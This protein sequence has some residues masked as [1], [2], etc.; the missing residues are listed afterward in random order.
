MS[1]LQAQLAAL[2]EGNKNPGLVH[3]VSKRHEEALG[4]GVHYSVQQGHAVRR[5][6]FAASYLYPSAKEA[7]KVSLSVVEEKAKQAFGKLAEVEP[8]LMDC[9]GIFHQEAA[10]DA[11]VRKVLLCLTSLL[12]ETSDLE[13]PC[14]AMLEY[15]VRRYDVHLRFMEELV[16]TVVSHTKLLGRTLQLVDLGSVASYNWLR[17]YA[18]RP[19]EPI[20]RSQLAQ[21]VIHHVDWMRRLCS[22]SVALVELVDEESSETRRGIAQMLSFT[23]TLVVEG[24]LQTNH[25]SEEMLR[26]LLPTLLQACSHPTCADWRGWGSVVA[27]VVAEKMDLAPKTV[28][29]ITCALL[30][31][32]P[33]PVALTAALAVLLPPQPMPIQDVDQYLKV[34]KGQLLGCNLPKE[35]FQKLLEWADELP[36]LLGELNEQLV[37]APFVATLI[38]EALKAKR[39]GLVACLL[40]EPGLA[41]LWN[42]DRIA[43]ISSLASYCWNNQIHE[44]SLWQRLHAMD[45]QACTVTEDSE[46]WTMT[47]LHAPVSVA[48]EDADGTVRLESVRGIDPARCDEYALDALLRRWSSDDDK[49]VAVEAGEKACLAMSRF[50]ASEDRV[51]QILEGIERWDGVE[52]SCIAH[53]LRMAGSLCRSLS[54]SD[55]PWFRLLIAPLSYLGDDDLSAASEAAI[56]DAFGKSSGKKTQATSMI[57]RS[58]RF[59]SLLV[60]YRDLVLE[61]CSLPVCRLLADNSIKS[62]GIEAKEALRFAVDVLNHRNRW[63]DTDSEAVKAALLNASSSQSTPEAL[64][65]IS[66]LA[67]VPSKATFEVVSSPVIHE[68]AGRVKGSTVSC[69]LV[70][71]MCRLDTPETASS[72]LALMLEPTDSVFFAALAILECG[73]LHERKTALSLVKRCKSSSFEHVRK[74]VLQHESRAILGEDFFLAFVL[75]EVLKEDTTERRRDLLA[76]CVSVS[77]GRIDK[78][79]KQW[80]GITDSRGGLRLGGAVLRAMRDCGEDLCPLID[81]WNNAGQPILEVLL[82]ASDATVVIDQTDEMLDILMKVLGGRTKQSSD[83][84]MSSGPRGQGGRRRSYSVGLSE[85]TSL[86]PY[87]A[88]MLEAVI[89]SLHSNEHVARRVYTDVVSRKDWGDPIF[90]KLSVKKRTEVAVATISFLARV[91]DCDDSH[92]TLPFEASDLLA[93]L[94]G[95]PIA[96][97]AMVVAALDV[98]KRMDLNSL[99][100]K[101]R[102]ALLSSLD[103]VLREVSSKNEMIDEGES[104]RNAFFSCMKALVESIPAGGKVPAGLIASLL[105]L[106]SQ[107]DEQQVVSLKTF[108]ARLSCIT[109]ISSMCSVNHDRE[110]MLQSIETSMRAD[111]QSPLA[112]RRSRDVLDGIITPFFA[113]SSGRME[114]RILPLIA[115]FIRTALDVHGS[116]LLGSFAEVLSSCLVQQVDKSDRGT[117]VGLLLSSLVAIE[118]SRSEDATS[119]MSITRKILDSLPE[120]VLIPTLLC[121][122]QHL[123]G[124][125]GMEGRTAESL[126]VVE[127]I[128]SFLDEAPE[129]RLYTSIILAIRDGLN[130]HAA[131]RFLRQCADDVVGLHLW[132]ELMMLESHIDRE[133][134]VLPL[135]EECREYVQHRLPVPLFL[136]SI[137]SWVQ[138]ESDDRIREVALRFFTDRASVLDPSAVEFDLFLELVEPIALLLDDRD[139]PVSIHQACL[140]AIEQ[141]ARTSIGSSRLTETSSLSW[142]KAMERVGDLSDYHCSSGEARREGSSSMELL[143]SI[144]LCIATLVRVLRGRS[145]P[146]LMKCMP[147][148]ISS[149]SLASDDMEKQHT[150]IL[151]MS[152]LRL[153]LATAESVPQFMTM[154]LDRVLAKTCLLSPVFWANENAKS[155][156]SLARQ[157]EA[158]ICQNVPLRVLLPCASRSIASVQEPFQRI[159]LL[160]LVKKSVEQTSSAEV[161]SHTHVF[162]SVLSTAFDDTSCESRSIQEAAIEALVACVMKLSEVQLRDLYISLWKWRGD[163]YTSENKHRRLAF[164]R[165]SAALAGTVRSIFLPC[166]ALVFEDAV[167]ELRNARRALCTAGRVSMSK[168]MKLEDVSTPSGLVSLQAVLLCLEKALRADAAD[169]GEWV[170]FN[171]GCRFHDILDPLGALLRAKVPDDFPLQATTG[172]PYENLVVSSEDGNVTA[173]LVALATAA[174][175]E[176]L[177]KPLNHEVLEACGDE[178]R[179]EVRKAGLACLCRL[180]T[181]LGEEFMTLLPE[182]LPV[183][184]EVLEDSDEAVVAIAR[185]CIAVAEEMTGE[186]LEESL[187]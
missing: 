6:G 150:V 118:S 138:D 120:G 128:G 165:A 112:L 71:V 40:D 51:K 135:V 14:T 52:K 16:W 49:A 159:F 158:S 107:S 177:W 146:M 80:L 103:R 7:A 171:D 140:I 91:D 96:K 116:T 102:H 17:P 88:K 153:L 33:S 167:G 38:I 15:L 60:L 27:S 90:T 132:Q 11:I 36:A 77:I 56:A 160:Q 26:T 142:V 183:L 85:S 74:V 134:I 173:T 44:S 137:S 81:L 111:Q 13:A 166:L 127:R 156:E 174:G 131:D 89:K 66:V 141:L 121:M 25:P 5:S 61:R 176:Q 78:S 92:L 4:R 124:L 187:R 169:G 72:R 155:Y 101:D 109:L 82:Q 9:V 97:G 55:E 68:I 139:S 50:G 2:Q 182:C 94:K 181:T 39:N 175:N 161:G 30:S 133:G 62:V 84:V 130:L 22:V 64:S 152:L 79:K 145:L 119:T 144:A 122:L 19:H 57:A 87:P 12:G 162:H 179:G 10:E 43:W 136:A 154:H 125:L 180:L 86:S 48:L 35:T 163:G 168:R 170:R 1:S 34:Y 58:Q 31:I 75:K 93:A 63:R 73:S 65:L 114:S 83:V 8:V 151:R 148:L 117:V 157:V 69:V 53:G 46:F 3:T 126:A 23:C 172:K 54:D 184:S 20:P 104:V 147:R 100:Q 99:T 186:N 18:N 143:C 115:L 70:E 67:A 106:I 32:D 164:W 185:E 24:L 42:D 129:A 41:S 110:P 76:H 37:I 28:Q 21:K 149:I 95:I 113:C 98:V 29:D 59:W 47:G 178:D 45:P 105:D 108:K 123:E